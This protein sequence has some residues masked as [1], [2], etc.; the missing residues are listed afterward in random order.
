MDIRLLFLVHSRVVCRPK[1]AAEK[2]ARPMSSAMSKNAFAQ[3]KPFIGIELVASRLQS[4]GRKG[5]TKKAHKGPVV[6]SVRG[7]SAAAGIQP[8]QCIRSIN[9]VGVADVRTFNEL[10][11]T[12]LPGDTIEL[13]VV[14]EDEARVIQVSVGALGKTLDDVAQLRSRLNADDLKVLRQHA[15][16]MV[17]ANLPALK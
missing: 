3:L 8:Q 1:T 16:Q 9:G 11:R 10:M 14:T 12:F 17:G 15:R 2:D 4:P 6:R 13:D 5:L 7:P